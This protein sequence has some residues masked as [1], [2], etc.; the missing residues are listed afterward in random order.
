M[1]WRYI[2]GSFYQQ[3]TNSLMPRWWY[4]THQSS[5]FGEELELHIAG[6]VCQDI[7]KQVTEVHLELR[8]YRNQEKVN[9]DQEMKFNQF[10]TGIPLNFSLVMDILSPK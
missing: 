10:D 6:T 5:F 3:A 7:R 1:H 4:Q 9:G 2:R 8:E